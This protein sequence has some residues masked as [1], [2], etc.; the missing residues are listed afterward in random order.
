MIVHDDIVTNRE[1]FFEIITQ[2]CIAKVFIHDHAC[3]Y[4]I[5][6]VMHDFNNYIHT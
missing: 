4:I 5:K 1:T 6:N 2:I 3:R